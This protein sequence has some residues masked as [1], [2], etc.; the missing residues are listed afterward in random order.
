M[1]KLKK[2]LLFSLALLPFAI[3]AGLF[4]C[5]YQ[6]D[7]YSDDF[8]EQT[9]AQ[10]GSEEL[11]I[12]IS[13][14]Q[15]C[16]YAIICGFFGY[17]LSEKTGLLKS[18][19]IESSALVKILL[20]SA[21]VGI[22]FSL[23][24]WTFGSAVPLIQEATKAGLTV[25]CVI[26]SV[27]YGG[28]IE[29]VMM[30]LFALSLIVFIIWKIFFRKKSKEDIP[31]GVFIAANVIAALLFAAGHLPAT[32]TTFGELTPLILF[33]CF[34]LNGGF[35]YVFGWIY[36]KYGIQYSIISHLGVHIISK[37]ILIIFI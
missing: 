17:I 8:I 13:V 12:V 32:I 4:T 1:K 10:I 6:F 21:V 37:L 24:Y 30:R 27:F 35:G 20:I 16:M 7:L 26:A 29:E 28:V 36:Q 31:K 2:P 33:R 15:V 3:V 9:I 34:L 19:K 14:I 25:N 23:D 11:L 5:L 22:V 18:F